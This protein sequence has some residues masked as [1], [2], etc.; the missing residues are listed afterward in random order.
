MHLVVTLERI[1]GRAGASPLTSRFAGADRE[2]AMWTF[3]SRRAPALRANVKTARV[4]PE[5]SKFE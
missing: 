3:W 4:H 5:S 2:P 1:I